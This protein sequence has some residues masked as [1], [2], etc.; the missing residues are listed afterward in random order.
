MVTAKDKIKELE[1][2]FLET[3]KQGLKHEVNFVISKF[4]ALPVEEKEKF[5]EQIN[6][7]KP[8]D[9]IQ[10]GFELV[11]FIYT[12]PKGAAKFFSPDCEFY[13]LSPDLS[14]FRAHYLRLYFKNYLKKEKN[15]YIIEP[16]S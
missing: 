16:V 9:R 3:E 8:E 12:D 7:K 15:E 13:T 6:S 4:N 1:L 14:V 2:K 10:S 5:Y 11:K